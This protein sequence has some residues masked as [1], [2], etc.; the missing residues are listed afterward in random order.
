MD[1]VTGFQR[2]V[3]DIEDR[4]QRLLNNE[5]N[6]IPSP[7]KKFRNDFYGIEQ[8]TYYVITSYTKGAKC[9]AKGTQIRMSDN[10]LKNIEDIKVGDYVMSPGSEPAK[11]VIGVNRGTA[12]LYRVT[13]QM[14]DSFTV[15]GDHIMYL[16]DYYQKKY[17]TMSMSEL[18]QLY[19]KM[20]WNYFCRKYKMVASDAV[21]FGISA[22]LP[23]EPYFYGLWL[24]DGDTKDTYVTTPNK[25]IVK[26]LGEYAFRLGC[27]VT[28]YNNGRSCSKYRISDPSRKKGGFKNALE[29]VCHWNKEHINP[30]YL[31][32]SINERYELLAGLLDTD[33]YLNPNR[34]GYEISLQYES[35]IDDIISLARS[36]GLTCYKFKKYNKEYQKFYF[37]TSISGINCTHIPTKVKKIKSVSRVNR[38][39]YTFKIEEVGNGEFYG[40]EVGDNHLFLLKD[41]TIVHNSQFCSYTF[42]YSTIVYAYFAKENV[43]FKIIYF[44]LEETEDRIRQRF[45]SWLL[46]KKSNGGLRISPRDLRSTTSILDE[47]IV[48]RIRQFDIDDICKY[49]DDHVIFPKESPNPTGIYKFCK[50]YAEEHGTVKKKTVQMKDEFGVLQD[51]EIFDSYEQDN[52]NEYRMIIIDTINLI[53]TERGMT[54]KQSIDKL[55]EY[56]AKYL[57]NRYHYSPIVI[58]QQA[59][60]SEG[61]ESFKLGRVRP[62]AYGAGDSK[63]T[64]R[65]ANVALGLF[66]PFRF[67]IT[68]YFGYDIT[69]LKDHIRFLEVLVNR[70]GEMG[71]ILPL[72]FDGAVC[73][74][75]ELPKS[76]QYPDATPADKAA[77]DKV[78]NLCKTLSKTGKYP[79]A[80]PNAATVLCMTFCKKFKHLFNF[81]LSNR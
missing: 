27:I 6:C 36:L 19:K 13:S 73:D 71:G 80:T 40:F 48:D 45:L 69:I 11:E 5:I 49:F 10:S 35:L 28:S 14:Y 8:S 38:R 25:E 32:A 33:G 56:L 77:L 20:E 78:Y 57:R 52:P 18:F 47:S 59:F 3:Q 29:N 74:F 9:F 61:N 68:E 41:Y 55:S 51:V 81:N 15:N 26:Y 58:Q 39:F 60:E 63:Y 53:D 72:W 75:R 16:Y 7:F 76:S 24:G 2:T 12:P 65:D 30:Q 22:S 17:I 70:D 44:P 4:R 67:G 46:F 23:I 21:D 54:L 43:D 79:V 42:I 31:N 62:S 1:N 37:A 66:S 64:M 34:S 50:Q